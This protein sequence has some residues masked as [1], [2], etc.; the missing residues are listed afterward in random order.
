MELHE[1]WLESKDYK[2]GMD[3]VTYYGNNIIAH[4]KYYESKA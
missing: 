2:N 4:K 3:F 1:L